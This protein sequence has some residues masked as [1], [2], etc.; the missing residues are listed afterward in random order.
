MYNDRYDS[1]EEYEKEQER[2]A[3]ENNI[4]I[5]RRNKFYRH[6]VKISLIMYAIA[7]SSFLLFM[8]LLNISAS[9]TLTAILLVVFIISLP[10]ALF[11]LLLMYAV[12]TVIVEEKD[13]S[14]SK[15]VPNVANL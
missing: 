9:K 4:R 1:V 11:I 10:I 12:R 15:F 2:L 5:N 14:G 6:D 13:L 7:L 3:L 8:L